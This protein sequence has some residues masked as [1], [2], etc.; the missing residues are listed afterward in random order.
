MTRPIVTD[1]DNHVRHCESEVR[2][3]RMTRIIDPE[4]REVRYGSI[5][6]NRLAH[7]K[8]PSEQGGSST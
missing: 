2:A 4:T 7:G 6:G 8:S 5:K 1:D 3:G